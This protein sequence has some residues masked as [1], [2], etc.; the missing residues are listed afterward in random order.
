MLGN[1]LINNKV[2]IY[3]K[4]MAVFIGFTH[5]LNFRDYLIIVID[6]YYVSYP[7]IVLWLLS[8][9]HVLTILLYIVL[10]PIYN[11]YE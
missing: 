7:S 6:N 3:D 9:Y 10:V 5:L 11:K 1:N 2:Y 8:V 4:I